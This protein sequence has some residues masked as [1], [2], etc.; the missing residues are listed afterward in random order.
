MWF[1]HAQEWFLHAECDF[2]T[3]ECDND[4]H[5]SNLYTQ[6]V[7]STRIV[8]LTKFTIHKTLI[9]SVLLY[10]S[11]TWALT[12]R[13]ECQLLVIERKVL[14]TIYDPKIENGVLRRR[15]NHEVD[16]EFNSQNTQRPTT[17]SSIQ[18]QTPW[19]EKSRKT[20]IQVGGW[21]EHSH[22]C[23]NTHK[24]EFYTQSVIL[25]YMSLIMTRTNVITTRTSVISTRTRLISTR[26]V[27]L[28]HAE[29]D[30]DTLEC[31]YDTSGLYT[32]VIFTSCVWCWHPGCVLNN[33]ACDVHTHACDLNT[34]AYNV[35]TRRV[36]LL[37]YNIYINL[38]CRQMPA[39]RFTLFF[40]PSIDCWLPINF[41]SSHILHWPLLY[42]F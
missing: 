21:V 1:Q 5:E 13:E 37:Y 40:R 26:R 38:R 12:K 20:E 24:I 7:I 31:D 42:L 8:I 28:P 6:S 32:S 33:H 41:V 30:Y 11:E 16:K 4:T 10:G 27:R 22:L 17:K 19:K 3:H 14:R 29:C 36:K 18:S 23:F 9:C 2:D 35:D 34:L 39:A 25:T 15:N